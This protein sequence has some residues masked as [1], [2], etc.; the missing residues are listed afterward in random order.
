M[1]LTANTEKLGA[2]INV[3]VVGVDYLVAYEQEAVD[4]VSHLAG[5]GKESEGGDAVTGVSMPMVG[6]SGAICWSPG[7][8]ILVGL[9]L[10][11]ETCW[12]CEF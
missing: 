12:V 3:K 4:L 2:S 1:H 11:F 8:V 5:E 7:G 6:H 9:T 10:M